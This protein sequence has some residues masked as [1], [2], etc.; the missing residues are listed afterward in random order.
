[1][2]RYLAERAGEP[3]ST[4]VV[5]RGR[6]RTVLLVSRSYV[7]DDVTADVIELRPLLTA[8]LQTEHLSGLTATTTRRRA[9]HPQNKRRG[10][11]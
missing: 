8:S 11:A 1:V 7:T 2:Q 4:A 9:L 3:D 6:G 10:N 5:A